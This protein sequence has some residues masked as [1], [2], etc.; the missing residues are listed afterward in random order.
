MIPKDLR[1]DK[2]KLNQNKESQKQKNVKTKPKWDKDTQ[3]MIEEERYLFHNRMC[4]RFGRTNYARIRALVFQMQELVNR[5]ERPFPMPP[6][7]T[8]DG[9]DIASDEAI[10]ATLARLDEEHEELE[11]ELRSQENVR[12]LFQLF[13]DQG[14]AFL[15]KEISDLIG[16]R[17][18]RMNSRI[19]AGT[20][21]L[22]SAI[23]G[24]DIFHDTETYA[25]QRV[26]ETVFP[27]TWDRAHIDENRNEA[28]IKEQQGRLYEIELK[29]VMNRIMRNSVYEIWRATKQKP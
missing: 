24:G 28:F 20:A 18:R 16:I 4:F 14:G 29:I 9:L 27:Y 11:D 2:Q 21:A 5:A 19:D 17:E 12:R 13:G 15:T 10:K 23:K 25:M 22:V 8:A 1:K 6:G 7:G 3:K 26:F